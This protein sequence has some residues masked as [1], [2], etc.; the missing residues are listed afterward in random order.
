MFKSINISAWPIL[1]LV[2]NFDYPPFPC[3]I[4]CGHDKPPLADYFQ[5]FIPELTEIIDN[6]LVVQG[7]NVTVSVRCFVCDAPAKSY[8]EGTVGHTS[9]VGCDRCSAVG[10]WYGRMTIQNEDA[11]MLH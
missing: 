9:Y 7:R 8:V 11:P 1:C 4:W 6:G 10:T 2:N 5:D 3:A